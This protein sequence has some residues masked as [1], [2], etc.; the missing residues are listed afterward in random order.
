MRRGP[1]W[2]SPGSCR[3]VTRLA[4]KVINTVLN[5]KD[6]M[7]KGLLATAKNIEK[8]NQGSVSATRSVLRFANKAG[9]AVTDFAKK[10]IKFGAA[11]AT[12]LAAGFLKSHGYPF[13]DYSTL[14][15][16]SDILAATGVHGTPGPAAIFPSCASIG[17]STCG[18]QFRAW[19]CIATGKVYAVPRLFIVRSY[20]DD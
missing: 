18:F 13:P 2:G 12:G 17:D 4:G 11:A 6:N 8:V 19:V 14:K 16:R 1:H 9:T 5:M 10:T 15:K 7:S 3:E 20:W